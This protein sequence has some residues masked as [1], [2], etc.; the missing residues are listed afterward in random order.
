[1]RFDQISDWSAVNSPD[2]RLVLALFRARNH[3]WE[4]N[5]RIVAA[6][7]LT[8]AQFDTLVVLR[9][10]APPHALR[11]SQMYDAI[12]VTSGGMTKV[13]KGLVERGL[14][15][16][17]SD[18][19]D[20]RSQLVQITEAGKIRIEALVDQLS[21]ANS[22]LLDAVLS[23]KEQVQFTEMLFRLCTYLDTPHAKETT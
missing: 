8:W 22:A 21:H 11:P 7:G 10:A 3:I 5:Q 19:Q 15:E 2:V 23:P 13:L 4:D 1:M 6:Q 16:R 20:A 18:P 17:L 14:V 12:Q 9:L